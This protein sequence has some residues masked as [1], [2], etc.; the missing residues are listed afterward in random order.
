MS[1]LV[2]FCSCVFSVLLTLRLP[3]LGKRVL[4]LVRF[5]RLFDLR[6]FGFSVPSSSWCLGRDAVC[7]YG[8]LW[9]IL[10]PFFYLGIFNYFY[11]F[12]TRCGGNNHKLFTELKISFKS[13]MQLTIPMV[14]L[15]EKQHYFDES[16]YIPTVEDAFEKLML[17]IQQAD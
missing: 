11:L 1:F 3:R 10:S 5:V 7:D 12:K 8:T 16:Q 15:I 6:L 2:L 4:V 9:T 17:S 13:L 14:C